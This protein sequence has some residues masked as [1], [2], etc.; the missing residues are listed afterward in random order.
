MT[1]GGDP[2]ALQGPEAG[3]EGSCERDLIWELAGSHV[4][5]Q[6]SALAFPEGA[7]MHQNSR[8]LPLKS[9]VNFNIKLDRE[10]SVL[11]RECVGFEALGWWLQDI[12]G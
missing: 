5:S 3:Q 4:P 1:L 12:K 9:K 2:G 8:L 7:L 10:D 11:Q 6:M